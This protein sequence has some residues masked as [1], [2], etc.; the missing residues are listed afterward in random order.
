M[1]S[2]E[3]HVWTGMLLFILGM[4]VSYTLVLL[5]TRGTAAFAA[6]THCPATEREA[7]EGGRC[8]T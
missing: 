5:F 2:R 3:H 4:T 8:G 1:R 6:P 7:C